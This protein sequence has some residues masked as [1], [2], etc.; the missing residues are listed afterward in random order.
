[1]RSFKFIF[2]RLVLFL[3]ITACGSQKITYDYDDFIDFSQFKTYKIS[4]ASTLNLKKLDS[5]RF[6]NAF[7]KALNDKNLTFSNT[8]DLLIVIDREAHKA[9]SNTSVGLGFGQ[10]TRNLGINIGGAIP[11][12]KNATTQNITIDFRTVKNNRLI[13]QSHATNTTKNGLSPNEKDLQ[14]YNFFQTI[15]KAYPPSKNKN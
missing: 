12:S 10:Q 2:L 1:M 9:K 13:W 3:L 4:A 5:T 14:F 8:P 11:L 7:S 15:L 6:I